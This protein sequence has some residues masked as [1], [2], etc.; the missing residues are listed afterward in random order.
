MISRWV[1]VAFGAPVDSGQVADG[2]NVEIASTCEL[3]Q[4]GDRMSNEGFGYFLAVKRARLMA[5]GPNG[6]AAGATPAPDPHSVDAA[7]W[8]EDLQAA[9]ATLGLKLVGPP[10]VYVLGAVL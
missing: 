9:A 3:R 8:L 4:V 10:G 7:G 2:F 6:I 5:L 1:V